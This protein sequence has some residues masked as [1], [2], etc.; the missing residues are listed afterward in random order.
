MKSLSDDSKY[1]Y[2]S[3]SDW[4]TKESYIESNLQNTVLRYHT[5]LNGNGSGSANHYLYKLISNDKYARNS[6]KANRSYEI[7]LYET[8]LNTI[9]I[10]QGLW[11]KLCDSKRPKLSSS[12]LYK[13]VYKKSKFRFIGFLNYTDI[14]LKSEESNN[15][16]KKNGYKI[17]SSFYKKVKK[18]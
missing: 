15:V 9:E 2:I 18:Y 7:I 8:E 12:Y 10:V 16:Y 11:S 17:Y 1:G 4:E 13:S 5:T 6:N 3:Y 14:D